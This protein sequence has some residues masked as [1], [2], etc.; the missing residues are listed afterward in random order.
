MDELINKKLILKEAEN[1][2]L[3]RKKEFLK[4]VEE[5]WERTLLKDMLELKSHE[6]ACSITVSDIEVKRYYYELRRGGLVT[7][8]LSKSYKEVKRQALR[9]KELEVFE[10]WANE[11]HNNT[12]IEIDYQALKIPKEVKNE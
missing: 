4:D 8:P 3:D 7:E 5:F 9:K 12:K 10:E 2:G 1:K 11:L 6:I